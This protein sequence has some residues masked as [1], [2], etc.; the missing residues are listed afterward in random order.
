MDEASDSR[1]AR[2]SIERTG[3]T[4]EPDAVP[5][6]CVAHYRELFEGFPIAYVTL[7]PRGIIQEANQT[8]IAMV[9]LAMP[10]VV[11]LPLAAFVGRVSRYRWR[12]LLRELVA[13]GMPHC[14]ELS[15]RRASGKD[16]VA[17]LDCLHAPDAQPAP[18]V[19]I[20]ISSLSRAPTHRSMATHA[21]QALWTM[22]LNLEAQLAA[23]N[24]ELETRMEQLRRVELFNR[25]TLDSVSLALAVIDE[26]GALIFRNR[27]W[28]EYAELALAGPNEAGRERC[29]LYVPWFCAQ[30]PGPH[31][32]ACL[33]IVSGVEGMLQGRR[34]RFSLEHEVGTASGGRWFLVRLT[35]LRG[36]DPARLILTHEDITSRKQA[37]IEALK[38]AR[39]FKS[40]LRILEADQEARSRELAREVHDQL[41]ATLTML[42]LGL[43]TALN[44]A[45]PDPRAAGRRDELIALAD[46]AL[47][48]VKRVT[49]RLRPRMLDT[50]GLGAALRCHGQEFAQMT[51]IRTTVRLQD[52]ECAIAPERATQVFRIV[53]EALTNVARHARASQVSVVLRHQEGR[54]LITVVDNGV[55]LKQG[56]LVRDNAFGIIGMR[57]R[58]EGLHGKLS[59]ANRR[60]HGVRLLL[61]LPLVIPA[62][63]EGMRS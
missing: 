23:R 27:V 50:L 45:T 53:Q 3:R 8:F 44:A 63:E 54:L 31:C 24:A 36:S 37:A 12:N 59:I 11:G 48:S 19:R 9:G 14:A 38:A 49:A 16:F 34:K 62:V 41:G 17:R 60:T 57:E 43:A 39:N 35:R 2:S 52:D 7:D 56:S 40:M 61:D 26:H 58:A 1:D 30:A 13:D 21:E 5:E 47:K 51:G 10:A 15:M 25:A 28:H 20:A 6:A 29:C 33:R 18:V 55:G 32:A 4:P 42:K 46:L 22:A